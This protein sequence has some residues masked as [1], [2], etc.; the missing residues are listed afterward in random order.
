MHRQI[1]T[2][3]DEELDRFA[4]EF[5]E[6]PV[7]GL[8]KAFTAPIEAFIR[9]KGK[10]IRSSLFAVA[11]RGYST[12]RPR[13]LFRSAASLELLHDFILIHDDLIDHAATR[14][15]EPSMHK[16][17]DSLFGEMGS[18]RFKGSDMA[19]VVGDMLYAMALHGFLTIGETPERKQ[20][21]FDLLT[22][23]AIYTG[24]GELDELIHTL[25][26]IEKMTVD[27]IYRIYDWKTGY[28][29][30]SAPL[31]MGAT[32]GGASRKEVDKL[33]KTGEHL[34]RAFQIRD[35]LLDLFGS[36]DRFGKPALTDLKEG[37]KT[38]PVYYAH[39][40]TRGAKRKQLMTIIEDPKAKVKDIRT[41]AK[42]MVDSGAADDAAEE[43]QRLVTLAL[44][45]LTSTRMKSPQLTF[46]SGYLTELLQAPDPD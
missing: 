22:K 6:P 42:I 5:R 33:L 46:L 39:R 4:A 36:G 30:F 37:K 14:R 9:R 15:G 10:R 25:K 8:P 35:D 13:N 16:S 12:R 31:A 7:S 40:N 2:R 27:D 26:P 18:R 11:Y 21:A 29:T 28:Y 19:L 45:T 1:I 24:C 20:R 23:T 43:M 44:E 38:L 41:A 17:L 32:L 34:G 3:I